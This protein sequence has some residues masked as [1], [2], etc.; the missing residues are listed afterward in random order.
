MR[1]TTCLSLYFACTTRIYFFLMF[2]ELF[3]LSPHFPLTTSSHYSSLSS[4]DTFL[5]LSQLP[6]LSSR[7]L[8]LSLSLSLLPLKNRG[9][10]SLLLQGFSS[11]LPLRLYTT[12]NTI[13]VPSK[14]VPQEELW[15]HKCSG[16][17]LLQAEE[18]QNKTFLPYRQGLLGC[19]GF[20]SKSYGAMNEFARSLNLVSFFVYSFPK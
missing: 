7:S 13:R 11:C 16:F 9:L 1:I 6:C 15:C 2:S 18:M 5:S 4:F 3:S 12:D 14:Q 8:S 17:E 20:S 10:L 19:I